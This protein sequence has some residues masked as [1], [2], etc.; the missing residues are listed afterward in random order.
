MQIIRTC[1]PIV[2][3]DVFGKLSVETG[4]NL[5]RISEVWGCVL[6]VEDT[7]ILLEKK[8]RYTLSAKKF[9][10]MNVIEVCKLNNQLC[11]EDVTIQGMEYR[12]KAF[13]NS[14]WS[15]IADGFSLVQSTMN[16]LRRY[17]VAA[18]NLFTGSYVCAQNGSL[19]AP[20]KVT[21]EG[22]KDNDVHFRFGL[23]LHGRL[24]NQEKGA[25]QERLNEQKNEDKNPKQHSRDVVAV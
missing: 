8:N 9:A 1:L 22:S 23:V 10:A 14:T 24:R 3:R 15:K 18:D 21:E 6:Y 19:C 20:L 4:L 5:C 11:S 2:Y 25:R 13:D 17:G 12:I 7:V 16:I